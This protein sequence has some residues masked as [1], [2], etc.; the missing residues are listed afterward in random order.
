MSKLT[1]D[2]SLDEWLTWIS[3]NHTRDIRL[4]L[5]HIK[6]YAQELNLFDKK[7]A[8][9]IVIIAGTNGKGTCLHTMESILLQAGSTVGAYMSP[10]LYEFNE[11]IRINGKNISDKALCEL[12]YTVYKK[13]DSPQLTFFEYVTLSAFIYF[14][15]L[16][17]DVLLLEI[18]LGGNLDAV[19]IIPSDVSI[20]T[21][22]G[23]DH[24]DRL[25]KTL[26][27]ISQAK[28]GVLKNNAV[29]VLGFP[30]HYEPID[31]AIKEQQLEKKVNQLDFSLTEES[32]KQWTFQ[33]QDGVI[34]HLPARPFNK[35]AIATAIMA[36]MLL[37]KTEKI[38]VE[39]IQQGI[40]QLNIPGRFEIIKTKVPTILDVAHNPPS[41][42][43]LSQSLKKL[44][45]T[46]NTY[47]VFG[48]L[49]DKAVAQIIEPFRDVV[50]KWF[51]S[52]LTTE[53]G[54]S[55]KAIYELFQHCNFNNIMSYSNP[56]EAYKEAVLHASNNDRI[57]VFGSFHTLNLLGKDTFNIS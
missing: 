25:G 56:N 20:I 27:E 34:E 37:R 45:I 49:E 30:E 38:K 32:N 23:L 40:A 31:N 22:I 21:S 1:K 44:P 28:A 6:K 17:M 51:L 52:G 5:E 39:H 18:G 36:C 7:L 46:G 16:E 50:S 48:C 10:H 11:R 3:E 57:V 12:F 26:Y 35:D 4:G 2:T 29:A 33:S 9:K 13:L 19:N 54:L 15:Q 24:T 8:K 47:A 53:R 41:S 14:S 42:Q 55:Q 43:W